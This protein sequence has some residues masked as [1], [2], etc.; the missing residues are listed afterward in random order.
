VG[1]DIRFRTWNKDEIRVDFK[2]LDERDLKITQEGQNIKVVY[3]TEQNTK[4]G[5][6]MFNVFVPSSAVIK[7]STVGGDISLDSPEWAKVTAST[8]GGNIEMAD[9]DGQIVASTTGGN[10][11]SKRVLGDAEF[12][13]TGG[14]IKIGSAIGSVKA[15]ATGGQIQ[16]SQVRHSIELTNTGGEIILGGDRDASGE[17][18]KLNC[19]SGSVKATAVGGHIT[20]FVDPLADSKMFMSATSGRISLHLPET[21]NTTIDATVKMMDWKK[22]A[23]GLK[24]NSEFSAE[25]YE[26]DEPAKEIRATY[27][28]NGGNKNIALQTTTGRIEIHKSKSCN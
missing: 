2:V 9:F 26:N 28:I 7:A 13:T 3:V 16:V 20:A 8:V 12:T 15:S 18:Q 24:I 21:A 22:Q 5:D 14:K 6:V 10:I 1:G 11:T 4:K 17:Y 25:K 27:I 23:A 19:V